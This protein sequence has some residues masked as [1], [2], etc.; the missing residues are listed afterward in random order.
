MFKEKNRVLYAAEGCSLSLNTGEK[1][2][3]ENVVKILEKKGFDVTLVLRGK[4]TSQTQPCG[5]IVVRQFA[6]TH[7]LAR[8]CSQSNY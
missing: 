5:R 4:R 6:R 3:I 7:V 2:R 8:G 1:T